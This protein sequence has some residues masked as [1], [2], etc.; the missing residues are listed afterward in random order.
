MTVVVDINVLWDVF[1]NRQ[2]H[3]EASARVLS[4]VCEGRLKGVFPS[5]GVT[6]LFYLIA[7]YGT[8]SDAMGAVD[9]VLSFFEVRCLDK[10]GWL[11]ARRL[12]MADFEDAVVAGLAAEEGASFIITRNVSDFSNAPVQAINPAN[13]LSGL[14]APF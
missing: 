13:F 9:R 14:P 6:T 11:F 12:P 5:H 8:H 3:Y 2:P 7:K 4:L 10:N 1:Q